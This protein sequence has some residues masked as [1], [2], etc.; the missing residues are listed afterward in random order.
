MKKNVNITKRSH[1]FK[2]Y[3]KTIYS[4]FYSN[5]KG[6]TI[7]NESDIDDVFELN[8]S[9][10]ISN[11]QKS[12]GKGSCWITDSFTVHDINISKYYSIA[13]TSYINLPKELDLPKIV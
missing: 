13:G 2:G 5:S 1:A 8:Y 9:T 12:L 10:T 11:I 6:E 4:T 7:P 3:A